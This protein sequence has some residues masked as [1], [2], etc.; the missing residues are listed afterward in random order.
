MCPGFNVE[1]LNGEQITCH[2][3]VIACTCDLPARAIMSNMVQYNGFY[4]CSHCLQK[5]IAMYV[6]LRI[7]II[8]KLY[9]AIFFNLIIVPK[10]FDELRR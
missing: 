5:G 10:F 9:V 7:Y 4:G 1:L 6:Y 2:V 3:S 8:I